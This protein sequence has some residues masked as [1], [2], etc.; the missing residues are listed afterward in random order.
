MRDANQVR[1][2]GSAPE[3][4]EG[5][6]N[7]EGTLVLGTELLVPQRTLGSKLVGSLDLGH[8]LANLDSERPARPSDV[9][10][11]DGCGYYLVMDADSRGGGSATPFASWVTDRFAVWQARAEALM[12][13][14]IWNE[15]GA[16]RS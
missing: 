1:G 11:D 15:P 8:F 6:L 10:L 4:A 16:T 12:R 9:T 3:L 2:R 13:L 14:A 7:Q 5:G